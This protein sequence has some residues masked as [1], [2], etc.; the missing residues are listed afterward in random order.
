MKRALKVM[1]W[2]GL[3][4]FVV[5]GYAVYRVAL[6]K[7]FSIIRYGLNSDRGFVAVVI[8]DD[9]GEKIKVR[10]RE[11]QCCVN[12]G[13]RSDPCSDNR[14]VNSFRVDLELTIPRRCLE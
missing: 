14:D 10:V 13:K 8:E 1:A 12:I 5:G 6:G 3:T 11:T 2:F 9:G 4:V 7:P